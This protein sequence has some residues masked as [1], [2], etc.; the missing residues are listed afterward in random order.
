M[1]ENNKIEDSKV[2]KIVDLIE[3][4]LIVSEINE[5]TE[6]WVETLT[7]SNGQCHL[8]VTGLSM[9]GENDLFLMLDI[10]KDHG[11]KVPQLLEHLQK[12]IDENEVEELWY[13][14]GINEPFTV[15]SYY[16]MEDNTLVFSDYN[17]ERDE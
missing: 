14:S 4:L 6:V 13:W 11:V 12:Y 16:I 3:S 15:D 9:D 17:G 5:E 7:P 10:D 1:I 8:P 2:E